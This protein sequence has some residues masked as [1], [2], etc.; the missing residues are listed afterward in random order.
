MLR[1]WTQSYTHS[2]IHKSTVDLGT[3]IAP[4]TN[5]ILFSVQVKYRNI[6]IFLLQI[7]FSTNKM[8]RW[9]RT[10]WPS[11]KTLIYQLDSLFI[12]LGMVLWSYH[13]WRV[14]PRS[15][16]QFQHNKSMNVQQ[17]TYCDVFLISNSNNG[18]KYAN[19]VVHHTTTCFAESKGLTSACKEDQ[20]RTRNILKPL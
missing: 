2:E 11:K 17:Y 13:S 19:L 12:Y 9:G 5:Q 18:S 1:R 6:A 20:I 3:I 10:R 7:K 14:W 4:L 16:V 15:L 8:L